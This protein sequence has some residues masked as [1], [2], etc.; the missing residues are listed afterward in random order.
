ML[1]IIG[2]IVG[3]LCAWGCVTIAK[4]KGRDTTLWGF[5]GFFFGI[6]ALGI[7]LCLSNQRGTEQVD[8]RDVF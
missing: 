2:I 4:N 3:A 7:L 8:V 1:F 5:L 6:F